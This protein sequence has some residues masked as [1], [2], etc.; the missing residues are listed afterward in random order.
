MDNKK[1]Y[2]NIE[3]QIDNLE[4]FVRQKPSVRESRMTLD[5]SLTEWAALV[6]TAVQVARKSYK[7]PKEHEEAVSK[8][9][10]EYQ[11]ALTAILML[12]PELKKVAM[13]PGMDI[14]KD[15]GF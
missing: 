6:S 10:S 9:F 3:E 1:T 5:A 12:P 4:K 11:Q 2:K 8:F 14:A 7:I 15:S 13:I